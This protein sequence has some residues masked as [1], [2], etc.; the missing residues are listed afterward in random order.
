ME[1]TVSFPQMKDTF[2]P[3]KK[4]D[5]ELRYRAVSAYHIYM[6]RPKG[7]QKY[8]E[9]LRYVA[10]RG[11]AHVMFAYLFGIPVKSVSMEGVP[12]F[13][14]AERWFHILLYHRWYHVRIISLSGVMVPS[15][16][17]QYS[18][19]EKLPYIIPFIVLGG[20]IPWI[21][22]DAEFFITSRFHRDVKFHVGA[23]LL[24]DELMYRGTLQQKEI[25]M[26]LNFAGF[27]IPNYIPD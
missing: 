13:K 24:A 20:W 19:F 3:P 27:E 17:Y 11:A 26:I 22:K 6:D 5:P 23:D 8:P 25:E 14:F 16:R 4:W 18:N 7:K 2:F 12:Q 1:D 10:F 21:R 9:E 15:R